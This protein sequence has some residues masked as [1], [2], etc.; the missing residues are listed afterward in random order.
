VIRRAPRVDLHSHLVPGVDDGAETVAD[1]LDGVAR[2]RE[3]GIGTIVTTPHLAASLTREA[4]AFL[5]RMG[6]MDR[7]FEGA[8]EAVRARFPDV[9]FTRANEVALDHPEPDLSDARLRLG[10]GPFL[11]V[12]WARFHPPPGSAAVLARLREQGVEPILAHPER[13]RRPGPDLSR[14]AAWREA[15]AVFQVNHGSLAGAFGPEAREVA[16]ELL[17]RGWVDLLSTDFHG[18]PSVPLF[19]DAAGEYFL[20]REGDEV[21]AR[22]WDL[23]TL[24]NPVRILRGEPPLPV[25]AVPRDEGLWARVVSLFR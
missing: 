2:M 8:R 3:R 14:L 4:D 5:E 23:L 6:E 25:P 13:Y 22:A 11:L 15:G 21:A 7:A 24:A 10:R 12:E 18:H 20:D 19:V 17:A 1:V 9:G 16:V